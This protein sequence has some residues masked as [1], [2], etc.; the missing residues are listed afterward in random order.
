LNDKVPTTV[1]NRSSGMAGG[2]AVKQLG[3]SDLVN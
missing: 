2:G 1:G 3:D